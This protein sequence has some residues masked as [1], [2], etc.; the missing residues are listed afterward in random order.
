M[1]FRFVI[2]GKSRFRWW[3]FG[4]VAEEADEPGAMSS[5]SFAFARLSHKFQKRCEARQNKIRAGRVL[6]RNQADRRDNA[7][8]RACGFEVFAE[9]MGSRASFFA[10]IRFILKPNDLNPFS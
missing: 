7:A 2:A 10:N 8:S 3:G 1:R 9:P 5:L 4:G 6:A